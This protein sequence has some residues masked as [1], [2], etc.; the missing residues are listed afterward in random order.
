MSCLYLPI[1]PI[2]KVISQISAASSGRAGQQPGKIWGAKGQAADTQVPR[3][4]KE[5]AYQRAGDIGSHALAIE[6]R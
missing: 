4:P 1:M 5:D 3:R 2:S 6:K